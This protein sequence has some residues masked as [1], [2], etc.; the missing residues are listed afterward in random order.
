[1]EKAHPSA[2][3][4]DEPRKVAQAVEKMGLKHVVITSVTRDDL[5]D[6]GASVFIKTV[7]EIRKFSK[8]PTIELLI[9]DFKAN[10]DIIR[11][12]ASTKPEI[13]GHNLEIV[14]RLYFLRPEADYQ[15]SLDVLRQIKNSDRNLFTKSALML[16]LG[17]KRE[18]ISQTLEDLR[19]VGCDFLALGQYLRPSLKHAEV[20]DYIRPEE[21]ESYKDEALAMGF[22]HVESGPYVRSSYRAAGYLA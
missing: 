13:I 3:D 9:P 10:A 22:K 5:P 21:F 11:N 14:S 6:G 7:S 20:S 8:T 16:G 18:E 15:R 2:L 12:I 4:E 19:R 1:V 17:E